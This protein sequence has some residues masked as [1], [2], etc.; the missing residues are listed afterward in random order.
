MKIPIYKEGDHGDDD[1]ED[2]DDD[3]DDVDVA[4]GGRAEPGSYDPG[5]FD[6]LNVDP[7]IKNL[8]VQAENHQWLHQLA[9]K[10]GR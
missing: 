2:E 9:I 6:H 5:E 8:F 7:E 4:A 1:D 3:D 10:N